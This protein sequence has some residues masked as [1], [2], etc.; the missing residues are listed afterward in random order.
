MNM[1]QVQRA[2]R[3]RSL[4][5]LSTMGAMGNILVECAEG[6]VKYHNPLWGVACDEV[7]DEW[8]LTQAIQHSAIYNFYAKQSVTFVENN[9]TF[10]VDTKTQNPPNLHVEPAV[11]YNWSLPFMVIAEDIESREELFSVVFTTENKWVKTS[12]ETGKNVIYEIES[13]DM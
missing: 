9:K 1:I 8:S 3:L 13:A 10:T 2:L 5:L 11:C 12:L 7:M 4:G 6:I